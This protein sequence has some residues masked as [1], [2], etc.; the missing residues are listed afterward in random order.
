MLGRCLLV[1]S[2]KCAEGPSTIA[3]HWQ[4]D[5]QWR[6][7]L[8]LKSCRSVGGGISDRFCEKRSLFLFRW[9]ERKYQKIV[10][11]RCYRGVLGVMFLERS[12]VGDF[13]EDH[14][15]VGVRKLDAFLNTFGTRWRRTLNLQP[16]ALALE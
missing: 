8:N 4:Q 7:L 9:D 5:P 1:D 16:M 13:E 6:C 14:A 11:F 3:S 12:A 2:R 10:R 15:L